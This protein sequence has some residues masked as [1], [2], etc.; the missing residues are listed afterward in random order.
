MRIVDRHIFAGNLLTTISGVLVISIALVIGNVI[1]ELLD[2]MVNQNLSL[3]SVFLF[4]GLALPF[5]LSFTIPW[6][7]LTAVLL[8]FGR[9]SANNEL[10]ALQT[11]GLSLFRICLPALLLAVI[12]SGFC[13]WLNVDINPKARQR[14]LD[15]IS[16]LATKDP[17][18]L[19]RE[20]EVISS[21]ADRQIS[22][23]AKEGN[24]IKNVVIFEM[25]REGA[26]S[27][28]ISAKDAKVSRDPKTFDFQ[29]LLRNVRIEERDKVSPFNLSKIRNGILIGEVTYPLSVRKVLLM[30][31]RKRSLSGK[32]FAEIRDFINSGGDGNPLPARVELHRRFSLSFACLA[33]AFIGIPLG[34]TAHRKETSAG[35]AFSLALA[36]GYLLFITLGRGFANTPIA[37]PILLMWLP[38]L[39][40]LGLG[41]YLFK[42]LYRP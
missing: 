29:I 27:R 39:I 31:D 9:M 40:F 7:F 26:P 3:R 21:F 17:M 2:L 5:T 34:I 18:V 32:T 33:F 19:F 25:N 10:L 16:N 22:I 1:R 8:I 12:L 37:Q 30:G 36:F 28:M 35:I 4:M 38:N 11:A 42:R 24:T 20:H 14:M 23:G 41:G 13:M 15:E 6:A